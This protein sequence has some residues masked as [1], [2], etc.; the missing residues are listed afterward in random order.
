[1]NNPGDQSVCETYS[2][3][4]ITGTLLTGSE[5]YWTQTGGTGTQLN[6][7]D[8]ITSSQTIY[9]Y[10]LNGTCSDEVSFIVTVY[11]TPSINNPGNQS[12]CESYTLGAITGTNLS[13]NEAY[14]D[15]AQS[16]GAVVVTGPITT[17]QTIWIYDFNTACDNEVSFVVTINQNPTFTSI[18]GGGVYCAGDAVGEV[19]VALAGTPGYTVTYTVDGGAP[20]TATGTTS[21]VILGNGPGVYAVTE[22]A[23]AN[24]TS[25]AT[26]TQTIT[27]NP[28]PSAPNAGSDTVYCSNWTLVPM[29]A[30][31]TGT[32]TWYADAALS[33]QL[34]VGNNLTPQVTVG[35][36]TYYVTETISGC[37][38]PATSITITIND[39]EIVVP[40]AFT[41]NGDNMNDFWEIV[42][43][44][45]GYPTSVVY[46]YNRWGNLVYESNKGSYATKPWDGTYNGYKLPVASY[47][48]MID[49]SESDDE[50][51]KGTV[52]IIQK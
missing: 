30:S 21:P 33:N 9:I 37:E 46:V 25:A 6:V 22:I 23:D 18:D 34:V 15:D 26:G 35:T 47:Y 10:D 7:G 48:Y 39:C 38:G 36:I 32:F 43:L 1:L 8:A 13:G 20:Q 12:A 2:L 14:Y 49:L 24:C 3:P 29:T 31:G 5:S 42:D 19:T 44:D 28:I 51:L 41:P 27:I 50:L 40:S 45:Q 4:A 52:T 11:Q 16:N 17:S